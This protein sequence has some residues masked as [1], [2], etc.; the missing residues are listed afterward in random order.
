MEDSYLEAPQPPQEPKGFSRGQF[1][2]GSLLAG[3][4][5]VGAGLL[6]PS[7]PEDVEE[8]EQPPPAEPQLLASGPVYVTASVV[9]PYLF[10]TMITPK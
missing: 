8:E 7:V 6:P 3:I 9:S 10:T 1:L 4:G 5:L 2:K